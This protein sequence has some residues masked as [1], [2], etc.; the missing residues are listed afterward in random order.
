MAHF[1]SQSTPDKF[2]NMYPRVM[3]WDT[4]FL[5]APR[6]SQMNDGQFRLST[7]DRITIKRRK[8]AK[9]IGM[10]GCETPSWEIQAH[11]RALEGHIT[12]SVQE[13]EKSSKHMKWF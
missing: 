1:Y 8:F 2:T 12:R 11:I 13:E 7:E 10:R 5:S 9:F 3:G 4:E 6:P